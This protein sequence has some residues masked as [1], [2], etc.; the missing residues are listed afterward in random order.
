MGSKRWVIL[1]MLGVI[2]GMGAC[3]TGGLIFGYGF[4]E[5]EQEWREAVRW[6]IGIAFMA[7]PLGMW[8]GWIR[9]ALRRQEEESHD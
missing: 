6:G 5:V 9:S 7:L 3:W 8:F 2:F 1:A 4:E